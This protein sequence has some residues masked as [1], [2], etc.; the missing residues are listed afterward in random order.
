[1]IDELEQVI[2]AAQRPLIGQTLSEADK[3]LQTF[4]VDNRQAILTKLKAGK[5]LAEAVAEV[6]SVRGG[7]AGVK[8]FDAMESALVAFKEAK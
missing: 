4:M 2:E 1:M 6:T 3:A 5:E 8:K 7:V